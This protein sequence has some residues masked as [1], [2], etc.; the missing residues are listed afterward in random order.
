[1]MHAFS[2]YKLQFLSFCLILR[3]ESCLKISPGCSRV[4]SFLVLFCIRQCPHTSYII[5]FI[6]FNLS[7][8]CWLSAF[9]EI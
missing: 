5:Q 7:H 4:R 3:M 6:E 2:V 1:M 9:G 8:N